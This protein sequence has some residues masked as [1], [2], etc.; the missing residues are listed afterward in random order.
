M[1]NEN[2]PIANSP[3][4]YLNIGS[5]WNLLV[6]G[7]YKLIIGA[8][9]ASGMT[10]TARVASF[11]T[12]DTITTTWATESRA[13]NDCQSLFDGFAKPVTSITNTAKP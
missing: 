1:I 5:G 11:E 12:W 9:G 7:V 8:L 13:W 10:N 2:K 6:G 4:T 3:E